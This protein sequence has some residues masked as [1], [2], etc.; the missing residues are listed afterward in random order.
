M[1]IARA[2]VCVPDSLGEGGGGETGYVGGCRGMERGYV[3]GEKGWG[4]GCGRGKGP[5]DGIWE[6]VGDGRWV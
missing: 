6:A 3:R 2:G 5:W 4:T 1:L